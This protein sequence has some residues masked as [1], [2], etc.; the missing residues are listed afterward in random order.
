M[1]SANAL[2][3]VAAPRRAQLRRALGRRARAFCTLFAPLVPTLLTTACAGASRRAP[4]TETARLRAIPSAGARADAAGTSALAPPGTLLFGQPIDD[5]AYRDVVR[6]F[7]SPPEAGIVSSA[8]DVLRD[9]KFDESVTARWPAARTQAIELAE[10]VVHDLSMEVGGRLWL[11]C[12]AESEAR[13]RGEADRALMLHFDVW[14]TYHVGVADLSARAPRQLSQRLLPLLALDVAA[15]QLDW[16]VAYVRSSTSS[17]AAALAVRA[18]IDGRVQARMEAQLGGALLPIATA[19]VEPVRHRW[20]A[21][22]GDCSP[23][24]SERVLPRRAAGALPSAER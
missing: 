24:T 10:V 11:G 3:R 8:D 13:Y 22:I 5:D 4:P 18:A 7:G 15:K 19:A 12:A 6:E 23:W 1:P 14:E 20:L 17:P 16:I 2:T 21:M 9:R